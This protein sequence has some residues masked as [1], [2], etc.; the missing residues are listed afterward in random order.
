[1]WIDGLVKAVALKALGLAALVVLAAA[2]SSSAQA[3]DLECHESTEYLVVERYRD[4]GFADFLAKKKSSPSTKISC[5]FS[6]KPRDFRPQERE[7]YAFSFIAL[8]GHYLALELSDTNGTQIP[9]VRIYD[10]D[11]KTVLQDI[12][13][14]FE[15]GNIFE[16]GEEPPS[17]G[18]EVWLGTQIEPTKDNCA[19]HA[20]EIDSESSESQIVVLRKAIFDFA[21]LKVVENSEMK[22]VSWAD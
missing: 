4:D 22:C 11:K 14:V 3:E 15:I 18:F 10:L 2:S 12:D 20:D 16:P 6:A 21:S 1:M 7:P 5:A 17:N 8:S 9:R 13:D 19:E